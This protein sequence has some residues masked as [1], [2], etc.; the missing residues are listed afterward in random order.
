[1][2]SNIGMAVAAAV[3]CIGAFFAWLVIHDNAVWKK[4][5]EAFNK[6]QE[7]IYQKKEEEFKQ[8][9]V[10]IDDNAARIRA[11]L[12]QKERE[13]D[14]LERKIELDAVNENSGTNASSDYL[15]AIVKQMGLTYGAKQ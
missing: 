3:A 4:A 5:T 6:A 12:Q 11:A 2:G 8:Q 10:V 14:E 9:T 1:M 7:E 13:A 15:K